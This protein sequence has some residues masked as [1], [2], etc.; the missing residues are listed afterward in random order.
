[1]ADS[2][3]IFE[4]DDSNFEQIVLQGSH[5]VPVL[6]DFWATWCQ[7]CQVL[8]PI[9]A[10]LTDAYQGKFILAKVNT[11]QQQSIAAQYG[12]RSIPT[13]KLFRN[14]APIDEFMG[15]LPEAEIR[16]FLDRHLPRASDATVS[17]AEQH[18]LAGDT[19]TA[20]A[21][22]AQARASDPSNPRISLAIAQAQ[23]VAGDLEAAAKTLDELPA[24]EQEKPETRQ[25]RAQ[26][27]FE[28]IVAG[29]PTAEVVAKRL[30]SAPDDSEARYWL[31]AHQVVRND[32]A[33]AAEN[34]LTIMQQDRG[35]GDDAARLALLKLFDLLGEDPAVARYRGRMFNL[36][37]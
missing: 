30:E 18:L 1:M 28:H 31:A 32:V 16:A 11:E 22:L 9:L 20:L 29:E 14:G 26:L 5:Q 8:M 25:V 35:F 34:L 36:L 27:F 24:E 6:V 33:S 3:F 4:I 19:D 15:A 2:P 17:Q 37:H 10:K 7:P 21:L 23:A 12:I 13:V